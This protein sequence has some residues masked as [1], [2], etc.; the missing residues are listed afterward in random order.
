MATGTYVPDPAYNDPGKLVEGDIIRLDLLVNPGDD[1]KITPGTYNISPN[2][3]PAQMWPGVCLRGAQE[4]DHIGTRWLFIGNAIGNGYPSHMKDPVFVE[5]GPLNIPSM[6]GYA[7]LYTG[8]VTIER[9]KAAITTSPSS[10]TAKM[11]CTT[12]S[13]VRGPVRSYSALRILR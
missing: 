5:D 1:D 3:Y 4:V 9:L 2:R 7:S 12:A 8:T 11:F 13:R 10:S 6:K